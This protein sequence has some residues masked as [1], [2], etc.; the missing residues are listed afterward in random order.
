MIILKMLSNPEYSDV[1]AINDIYGK[2]NECNNKEDALLLL[3]Y[4]WINVYKRDP[5]TKLK[6]KNLF[7]KT[8]EETDIFVASMRKYLDKDFFVFLS[9]A[10]HK[11]DDGKNSE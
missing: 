5:R 8:Q 10:S 1:S 11:R 3:Q 9:N 4:H 7:G 6:I 2:R